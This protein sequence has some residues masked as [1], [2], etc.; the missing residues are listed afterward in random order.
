MADASRCYLSVS[1]QNFCAKFIF[2][3]LQIQWAIIWSV[4]IWTLLAAKLQAAQTYENWNSSSELTEQYT[5]VSNPENF[6]QNQGSS[7]ATV[8]SISA[9]VDE[10]KNS[11][12]KLSERI[13]PVANL[14]NLNSVPDTKLH[15][16][17]SPSN[18]SV[19]QTEEN[20]SASQ[21]GGEVIRMNATADDS[22]LPYRLEPKPL[23]IAA[24]ENFN[25]GLRLPPPPP[26]KPLQN[27]NPPPTSTQRVTPDAVLDS[28]QTNFRY[29]TDNFGQNNL[30]IEPT[31]QFR[32]SNGNKILFKTGYDYFEQRGVESITNIPFQV[33]WE[34]KIG[35]VTLRTAAGVDFFDRLPLAVNL[36]AKVETPITQMRVSRSGKLLSGV[37]LS[38]NLEQGPYKFNARTLDNQI[39]AWRYGP[40]LYWQID[41]DTSFFSSLR[42]GNYNDGNFEVQ[43][44]S[45]LERKFGQFSVAANLFT[46]N[47]DRDFESKSGYFS[48]ED[49]LV[50]NAEVGWE[51]DIS[52]FLRCRLAANLGQQRL[53]GQFDNANTYQA[54]CTAKLSPS[55]EAD[56][57]YSFSNVRNQDTGGSA[58]S[59]NSITGQLR[60]KF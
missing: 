31:T 28:I 18:S 40:D 32:L 41:R 38:A 49:F 19:W 54:R 12:S 60:V 1:R 35:Q 25:P 30:F 56:L 51:G 43:S 29:D 55:V 22:K 50:Y 17:T 21:L 37:V 4:G 42:L 5:F 16:K 57:G 33:G 45:R 20:K 52:T 3:C 24:P 39:T 34:G 10:N 23:L 36:N 59:G 6:R 46:W 13:I 11:P 8:F 47:Y 48:P 26:P 58:Y 9:Q 53:K 15:I 27:S 14:E 7:T 2:K 44:F